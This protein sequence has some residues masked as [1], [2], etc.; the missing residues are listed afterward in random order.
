MAEEEL[1]EFKGKKPRTL[2]ELDRLNKKELSALCADNGLNRSGKRKELY[3]RLKNFYDFENGDKEEGQK[4]EEEEESTPEPRAP[5]PGEDDAEKD[6]ALMGQIYDLNFSRDSGEDLKEVLNRYNDLIF[7]NPDNEYL[8]IH[9]GICLQYMQDYDGAVQCY[10]DALKINPGN[11]EARMLLDGCR[12]MGITSALEGDAPVPEPRTPSAEDGPEPLAP[13]TEEKPEVKPEKVHI[14]GTVTE[15]RKRDSLIGDT[16][17][18]LDTTTLTESKSK[19]TDVLK[20]LKSELKKPSDGDGDLKPHEHETSSLKDILSSSK[21]EDD[22]GSRILSSARKL[23]S[24]SEDI[25]HEGVGE[26][27]LTKSLNEDKYKG[28]MEG[29]RKTDFDFGDRLDLP[30]REARPR[31][32]RRSAPVKQKLRTGNVSLD[33]LVHGGFMSGSNVLINGPTFL[34]KEIFLYKFAIMGFKMGI[35]CIIINPDTAPATIKEKFVELAPD[36]K[37]YEEKKLLSWL[38]PEAE[39]IQEHFKRKRSTDFPEK[40]QLL[41][42][43]LDYLGEQLLADFDTYNLVF[44]SLTP[45]VMFQEPKVVNKFLSKFSKKIK[46][47]NVVAL[48]TLDN[49]SLEKQEMNFVKRVMDGVLELKQEDRTEEQRDP[50]KLFKIDKL[51]DASSYEWHIFKAGDKNY[52]IKEI[53]TYKKVM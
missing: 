4:K 27:E 23:L 37:D 21:S 30:E 12:A 18:D 41:L 17:G 5:S 47:D 53:P 50:Q 8:M 43:G 6:R 26:P 9:R 48:Y 39:E 49:T 24:L 31:R 11:I 33:K 28:E 7:D 35:P 52:E 3:K 32:Q 34:A 29:D 45:M 14:A 22:F 44:F 38:D 46:D 36:I 15:P 51:P 40:H 13:D 1:P 42:D 10:V 19:L 20:E 25:E 16:L 2:K